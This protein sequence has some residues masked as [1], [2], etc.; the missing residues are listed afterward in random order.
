MSKIS[1]VI[2]R[3]NMIN[4]LWQIF[5]KLIYAYFQLSP[6]LK[7]SS[8]FQRGK[9]LCFGNLRLG[10][11]GCVD[12]GKWMNLEHCLSLRGCINSLEED[13]CKTRKKLIWKDG[14]RGTE[15]KWPVLA[16]IKRF[17]RVFNRESETVG[18]PT[19]L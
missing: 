11:F 3:T 18:A 4:S 15:K 10:V 19:Q 8:P 16:Y 9:L 7:S 5:K 13:T 1:S 2:N 14:E 17:W 6:L 12:P